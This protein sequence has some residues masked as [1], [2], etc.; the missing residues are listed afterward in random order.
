MQSP[1]LVPMLLVSAV[2]TGIAMIVIVR[3]WWKTKLLPTLLYTLAIACFSAMAL[4]LLLDQTYAPFRSWSIEVNGQVL[5]WSNILLAFFII[6]GFLFWY[7]AII[8]SEHDTPPRGAYLV[9]FI[10]G[11]ALIGELVKGDWSQ[12]FPLVI[13]A[14][15]FGILIIEIIRYARIIIPISP[16]GKEGYPVRFYFL[17]FLV[18]IAA[19]PVGVIL[20]NIPGIE[21]IGNYWTIPYSIGLLM[22]A[23]AVGVNPRLLY[24]SAARPLDLM[25]LNQDNMLVFTQRFNDSEDGV[26]T[27]LMGTALS[28]VLSLM[29]E[30]LATGSEL[31]R[32]D[33]GD[34]KILVEVGTKTTFLLTVTKETSRFR[35]VLRNLVLEF[36]TNYREELSTDSALVTAFEPFRDRIEEVLI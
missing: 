7:F 31:Q 33:H 22:T 18:W 2:I 20:A 25:I 15:A 3:S 23:Y 34:V 35:Q 8:Y 13:E 32:I 27:E 24:I 1:E 29:K 17:G 28:G 10:A 19:G 26:D 4:D 9:V 36:E 16:N 12:L 14:A 6:G 11:G 5:W 21:W 30:M